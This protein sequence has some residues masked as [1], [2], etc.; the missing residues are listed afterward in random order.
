V[1]NSSIRRDYNCVSQCSICGL[2]MQRYKTVGN[3]IQLNKCISCGFIQQD[4]SSYR[5]PYF[6]CDYYK[7]VNAADV[8]PDRPLIKYRINNILKFIKGGCAVDLGCGLGE[9]AI[10][11]A[12]NGFKTYA[13]DE[14]DN[15]I[16][17]LSKYHPEVTSINANIQ[18]LSK[19]S[20]TYDL[21]TLYHVLEHVPNYREICQM[22]SKVLNTK[23]V[24]VVEVPNVSGIKSILTGD[25]WHY[26]L[27]HHI[28]YFTVNTLNTLM[29]SVGL[30]LICYEGKYHFNYPQG[31]YIIDRYHFLLSKLGWSDII[32]T[33]WRKD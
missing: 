2:V 1:N 21:V 30:R 5:S 23:G 19:Y 4:L 25:R 20:S 3:N 33:Y 14:S 28:N 27:E 31:K 13:I 16:K 10:A 9:M 29:K 22:I 11:L 32:T 17:Y 12:K 18:D 6:D 8:L 15:A 24:L 26:Y 7:A